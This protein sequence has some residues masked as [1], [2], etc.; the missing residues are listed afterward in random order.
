MST[1]SPAGMT[2]AVLRTGRSA[3]NRT[4]GDS[5]S[6]CSRCPST[7]TVRSMSARSPSCRAAASANRSQHFT[8]PPETSFLTSSTRTATDVM[9]GPAGVP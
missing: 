2:A 6:V 1:P 7:Y 4:R 8:C 3:T 9:S 5:S